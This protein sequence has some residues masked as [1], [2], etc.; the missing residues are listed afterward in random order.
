MEINE[1]KQ[2][3]LNNNLDSWYIFYG[4]ESGVIRVYL[5]KMSEVTGRTINFADSII[6]VVNKPTSKAF[7]TIPK[8]YVIMDDKEFQTND[9]MWDKIDKAI[10]DDI[11]IF[12]YTSCD[13]RLKFWKNFKVRAV[14]FKKL[15][16][17]ILRRHIDLDISDKSKNKLISVCEESYSRI[18]LE[19]DKI[20][21]YSKAVGINQDEAL[22]KLLASGT[23]YRPA[24]DAIFDFVDAVLDRD[25][26][27]AYQLL[28]ESYECGEASMVLISV[29]YNKFRDLLQVQTGAKESGLNGWQ[30]K[31]IRDFVDNYS[32]GELI[33]ALRVIRKAEYGI[34]RGLISE[35]LSVHYCLVNII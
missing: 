10:K 3:I 18:L 23:I 26:D 12:W 6:D 17:R 13:A 31:N 30:Q 22:S 27:S 34:K 19:S 5:D 33:H 28:E 35:A 32:T 16:D 24:S 21:S 15:D 2:Q 20:T 9:R 7:I 4:E 14:E 11:V 29:L 25:V 1:V 8:L